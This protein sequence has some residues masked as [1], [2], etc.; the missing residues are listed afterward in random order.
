VRHLPPGKTIRLY[1][2]DGS[3]TGPIIAEIINWTG[4]VIVVLWVIVVVRAQLHERAK[5]DEWPSIVEMDAP[6]LNSACTS[7]ARMRFC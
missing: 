7:G 1:L 3:P 2:A 6:R 4:Q 5:R